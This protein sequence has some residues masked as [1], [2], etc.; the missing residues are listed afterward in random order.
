[1]NQAD[2]PMVGTDDYVVEE[3][4]SKARTIKAMAALCLGFL[5]SF[6]APA[7]A[8]AVPAPPRGRAPVALSIWIMPNGP[9]NN[10]ENFNELVRPFVKA[11]PHVKVDATVLPWNE[12]L[13]RIQ[14]AVKGGP[15][16]DI[17]QLG[18]TWVAAIASTGRLL[19]LTGKYDEKLF[20]PGV[21]ATT[22]I[23]GD[24][25]LA[26]RRFAMPWIV[27]TRALYYNKSM[28][29]QAGV[30]PAKDFDTWDSFK[31]ALHKLK[32]VVSGGKRGRPLGI[33]MSN[34]DIIHNL[35][36][37]IW[38]A[39]GGF[40][41]RSPEENG[42][43]SPSSLAGIEYF[44]G[45]Y[46]DGLLSAEA[47]RLEAVAV[48]DMLRRGEIAATIAFPIP[49]LPEDRFGI[50]PIPAGSRGR[51]TFLGGSTLAVLKSSK[52]PDEAVMLLKFL[53]GEAAQVRYSTFTGLLPA[54]SAQYDEL[55][56]ELDPF[57]RAFVQQMRHGKAYP[58]IAQ[59]GDIEIV[60]RDGLNAVWAIGRKPG[61][62][63]RTAVRA[64]LDRMARQIDEIMKR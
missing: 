50:A 2:A 9:G 49:S 38:G 33:P 64:Q 39:G 25:A 40:V 51:Y 1:M 63:D 14:K 52:H 16:P 29:A 24:S 46:R 12:A 43:D 53:A 22:A 47:D 15:A 54:A 44:V 30:D 48:G 41:A 13:A 10:L 55:L 60:L 37:W 32:N 19:D 17:A 26:D 28:C 11:N 62:Y 5:A 45:L 3:D 59:W 57:R 27:D 61:V 56:L 42:I 31:A 20:P 23:E 35:S 36:W 34:W 58:S 7:G 4:M 6:W 21:L 18:T 8:A